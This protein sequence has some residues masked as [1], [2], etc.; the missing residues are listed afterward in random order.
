MARENKTILTLYISSRR[1]LVSSQKLPRFRILH[2]FILTK[3]QWFQTSA[4]I[5]GK[6]KNSFTNKTLGKIRVSHSKILHN[7]VH[8]KFCNKMLALVL[9]GARLKSLEHEKRVNRNQNP[10][11]HFGFTCF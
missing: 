11:A 7:H 8:N 5:F 3:V 10:I 4:N 2:H 6:E 1:A 9:F